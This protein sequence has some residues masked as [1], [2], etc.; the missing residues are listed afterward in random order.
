MSGFGWGK[1]KRFTIE[2]AFEEEPEDAI[3]VYGSTLESRPLNAGDKYR[4][5][6]PPGPDPG[7]PPV[8]LRDPSIQ[9]MPDGKAHNHSLDDVST[10]RGRQTGPGWCGSCFCRL[11]VAVVDSARFVDAYPNQDESR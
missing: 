5:P 3:R 11:A 6:P 8:A 9:F 4:V 2:D 7:L 1:S 10:G